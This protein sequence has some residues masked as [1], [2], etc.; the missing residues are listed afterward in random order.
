MKLY[1]I[2]EEIARC[3]RISDE[4]YVDTESGEIFDAEYIDSLNMDANVKRDYLIKL[5]LNCK[6][7]SEALKSEAQKF[8]KRAKAEENKA[9]SIKNYLAFAQNGEKYIS[10]DGLHQITF[11]RTASVEITDITKLGTEYLRYKEPEADKK[12]ITAAIKEGKEVAGAVMV[13]KLSATI[14]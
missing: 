6:S 1:E 7:N 11:R 8:Q 9:E 2:N 4:E 14:K 13:D 5:Y 12:A 3:I 10:E